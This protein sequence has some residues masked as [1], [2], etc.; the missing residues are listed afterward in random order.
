MINQLRPLLD[1][2]YA[3][4]M[5][6]SAVDGQ[7][8]IVDLSIVASTSGTLPAIPAKSFVGPAEEIDAQLSTLL[9]EFAGIQSTL[10]EQLADL[11]LVADAVAAEATKKAAEKPKVIKTV[12]PSAKSVVPSG[13]RDDDDED[14]AQGGG[15]VHDAEEVTASEAKVTQSS[16]SPSALAA[17]TNSGTQPTMELFL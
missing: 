1:K 13:L 7:P 12:K 3:L 4:Q 14:L 10:S 17:E 16:G 5:L 15:H 6:V 11:K 2:G 9:N 8:G